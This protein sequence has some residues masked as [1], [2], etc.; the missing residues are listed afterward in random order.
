M[1]FSVHDTMAVCEQ[2]EKVLDMIHEIQDNYTDYPAERTLVPMTLFHVALMDGDLSLVCSA[3]EFLDDKDMWTHFLNTPVA[4]CF[5]PK[6]IHDIECGTYIPETCLAMAAFSG[7]EDL[8]QLLLSHGADIELNNSKGNNIFHDIVLLSVK[9]C[10]T[11]LWMYGHLT[12]NLDK[13]LLRQLLDVE[14][15]DQM[16]ALDLASY[17]AIPEMIFAILKTDGVYR[18]VDKYCG[19][20]SHV[21]YDVT[22]YETREGSDIHL[23]YY[24]AY[25]TEE[26]LVRFDKHNIFKREPL[27]SWINAKFKQ[28]NALVYLWLVVWLILLGVYLATLIITLNSLTLPPVEWSITLI[29][30][31]VTAVIVHSMDV[32][33]QRKVFRMLWT[34]MRQHRPPA[35]A[36]H[37]YRFYMLV[38]FVSVI[39]TSV[40]ALTPDDLDTF[41]TTYLG[42]NAT[43]VMFGLVSVLF[44]VQLSQRLGYTLT[45][46]EKIFTFIL[47]FAF[48]LFVILLALSLSFHVYHLADTNCSNTSNDTLV[49]AQLCEKENPDEAMFATF[50]HSLYETVLISAGIMV[51]QSIY[52]TQS[53]APSL[54]VALY[55]LSLLMVYIVLLNLMLALINKRIMDIDEHKESIMIIQK[56]SIYLFIAN[57]KIFKPRAGQTGFISKC[58]PNDKFVRNRSQ[59][60]VYLSVIET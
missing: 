34:R 40:V 54:A 55:V 10:D 21:R 24:L 9:H 51:P 30:L 33:V 11:A 59:E 27:M 47:E 41:S 7:K 38:F 32:F 5:L 19:T 12:R 8:I 23:L 1:V 58:M 39:S 48:I 57:N 2:T 13:Q 15:K 44:F 18:Y 16:V 45:A 26:E 53:E 31:Y 20:H 3:L 6:S 35:N 42:L 49:S 60:R 56:L 22:R 25:A 4:A 37:M 29:V 46:I 50:A 17:L 36:V 52:F 14:N 28:F 43:A